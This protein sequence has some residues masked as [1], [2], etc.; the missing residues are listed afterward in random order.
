[1]TGDGRFTPALIRRAFFILTAVV[2]AGTARAA[3]PAPAPPELAQ[4][5]KPDAAEA[6]HIVEQFQQ[7]GLSGQHYLEFQLR[8]LPRR[9]PERILEGRLW[10]GRNPR[11][12]I[13]RVTLRDA[14]GQERR[15][16]LQNGANAAA[17]SFAG[18]RIEQV[19]A[20][21]LF[22]PFFPGVEIS[23]FD[24]QMP[25][26]YWPDFALEKVERLRGRPAHVFFFR[27]PA[28][29]ATQNQSISG[30]RAYLDTQFDAP[31][32]TELIGRDGRVM[33]TLSLV[34]LK[35]V[36]GQT[37]VK[38]VDV[39]NELTRDKTRFQVTGVALKQEFSPAI[40]EPA[41]LAEDVRPPAP[42]RITRL[43]P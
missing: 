35:R 16:L 28:A 8:V 17:W 15:L 27:P 12:D 22:E 39:R 18:G 7:M 5:N 21:G 9:G 41:T 19:N 24:L 4:L 29:V 31:V 40:F 36:E 13:W 37:M 6:R 30:V 33:K 11:G 32:Q 34:D 3:V 14:S 25:F 2:V 38:T 20:G 26:F 43:A 1:M 23:P 10:G 42:E